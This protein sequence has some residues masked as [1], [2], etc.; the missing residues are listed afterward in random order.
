MG[1]KR[2]AHAR[3][4][5]KD[6]VWDMITSD[7]V[8]EN[9]RKIVGKITN[10]ASSGTIVTVFVKTA[11]DTIPIHFD[12]RPFHNMR[13]AE[14]DNIIGRKVEVLGSQEDQTIRFLDKRPRATSGPTRRNQPLSTLRDFLE[15]LSSGHEDGEI[16]WKTMQRDAKTAIRQ[17]AG[18]QG[19]TNSQRVKQMVGAKLLK[20]VGLAAAS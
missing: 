19:I 17:W 10:A 2:A 9:P 6:P 7:E 15:G 16:T 12:R 1:T 11:K 8:S 14:R 5:S 13:V 4:P 18:R 3:N 20:S